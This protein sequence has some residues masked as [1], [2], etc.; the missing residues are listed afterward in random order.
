MEEHGASLRGCGDDNA[1]ALDASMKLGQPP[2][3]GDDARG[4]DEVKGRRE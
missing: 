1:D 4:R 2:R 3:G